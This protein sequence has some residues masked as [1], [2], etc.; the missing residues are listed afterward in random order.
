MIGAV[1]SV[2]TSRYIFYKLRLNRLI[3]GILTVMSIQT[4][5]SFIV[6]FISLIII[7]YDER[8]CY[9]F[10]AGWTIGFWSSAPLTS[11]ISILKYYMT[12]K[13]SKCQI[14]DE[15]YMT[16]MLFLFI[17]FTYGVDVMLIVISN[18]FGMPSMV[19]ICKG[20]EA[21]YDGP[22]FVHIV[23]ISYL[24]IM[25]A[26]GLYC[27][28][29]L[30]AFLKSRNASPRESK[31]VPWKSDTKKE[32]L[33]I[34][35][36]ATCLGIVSFVII[37][38]ISAVAIKYLNDQSHTNG[39]L[40]ISTALWAIF[41]LPM[42]IFLTVKKQNQ[43]VNVQPPKHLHFHDDHDQ[44]RAVAQRPIWTCPNELQFHESSFENKEPELDDV[45]VKI[46]D[47]EESEV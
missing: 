12:M 6:M 27:D 9:P 31:L 25:M 35:V 2:L 13:A 29:C 20:Q 40:V 7:N 5:I 26:L 8:A 37:L 18:H 42:L 43:K 47:I 45:I 11:M 33:T 16:Y 41:L 19:L 23:F 15:T 24:V 28:I 3:K 4:G 17:S 34:P 46:E 38:A 36:R 10:A 30:Y 39:I 21:T 14:A 22:P 44:G 32:D 1:T